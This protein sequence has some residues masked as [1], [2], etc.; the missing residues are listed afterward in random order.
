MWVM[1]SEAYQPF[2]IVVGHCLRI[3]C[4]P[5]ED[6]ESSNVSVLSHRQHSQCLL[7]TLHLLALLL[8]VAPL[9]RGHLLII[10]T[11]ILL[12]GMTLLI[13]ILPLT[14][15][16]IIQIF[17]TPMKMSLLTSGSAT[18]SL[19]I[20]ELRGASWSA[21][22]SHYIRPGSSQGVFKLGWRGGSCTMQFWRL[23][24]ATL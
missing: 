19:P 18:S 9:L 4:L 1:T 14:T 11:N 20:V 8:L 15:F 16:I 24:W 7:N 23:P 13:P 3:K 2:G 10:N 22:N 6:V 5:L 17:I 21:S 12:L